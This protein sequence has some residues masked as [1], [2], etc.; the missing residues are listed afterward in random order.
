MEGAS[1]EGFLSGRFLRPEAESG[2]VI[3]AFPSFK[4]FV[5]RLF[6]KLVVFSV[7]RIIIYLE[8]KRMFFCLKFREDGSY[9]KIFSFFIKSSLRRYQ[10]TENID[11]DMNNKIIKNKV[12]I[13]LSKNKH[14]GS[15][16]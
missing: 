3:F 2:A 5:V 6:M 8:I 12:E 7:Y 13:N 9:I 11:K 10:D 16:R 4:F 14:Q 1:V 15:K